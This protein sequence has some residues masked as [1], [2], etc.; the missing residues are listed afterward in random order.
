MQAFLRQPGYEER[1]K[2]R[3]RSGDELVIARNAA[4]RLEDAERRQLFAAEYAKTASLYYQG[5]PPFE[6]MLRRI[7]KHILVM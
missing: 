6:D 3:F 5:Q 1:K 7:H 4:F 2:Q